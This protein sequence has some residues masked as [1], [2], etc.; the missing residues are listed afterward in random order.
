MLINNEFAIERYNGLN[1]LTLLSAPAGM[2]AATQ[3]Q[4]NTFISNIVTIYGSQNDLGAV[5]VFFKN[6][7]GAPSSSSTLTQLEPG[8]EYYFISKNTVTYPYAI[9]AIG[10]PSTLSCPKL[11]SCCPYVNFVSNNVSLS[12]PPENIYAY[13]TANVSGLEP[14]VSY[15]YEY[16]SVTANW[17][18]KISPMSG[19]FIP[20]GYS[21]TIDSVFRFCPDTGNCPNYLPYTLDANS[22]KE[23]SQKNIFSSLKIKLYPANGSDCDVMSD[24]VTIKCNK[25]LPNGS[26]YRPSVTISGSPRLAL[27]SA[28]CSNPI[29]VT[30]NV[31]GAEPGKEYSYSI[32]SWPNTVG[33]NPSSGVT[34]FGS[35]SGKISTMVSMSGIPSAVVKFVLNDNESDENFVDFTSITCS[36]SC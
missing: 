12:G 27:T 3:A 4:Y 25:C 32:Q 31:A 13:L 14:G 24:T 22:T 34:S 26:T 20:M 5:P 15:R 11:E 6:S 21:D 9:P 16:E 19:T 2:D 1:P 30:V 29:P 28:C 35:G 36:S 33:I 17:P 8:Q 10:G 18:S 23:Y 7:S